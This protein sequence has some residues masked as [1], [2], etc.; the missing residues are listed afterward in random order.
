[1][2]QLMQ[3]VIEGLSVI[4]SETIGDS[5][6]TLALLVDILLPWMQSKSSIERKTTLLILRTTLRSYHDSLKYT[7]PGGK[8][9]PGKL[10]GR[11]LSWS[12][13]NDLTLRPLVIDCVALALNIG[14]RHRSTL[15]DNSLNQDLCESKRIIISEDATL[16]YQ[17]VR[18]LSKAAC[19]R[20]ASGEIVSLAEGLIEGLLYRGEGGIAAGIAL[21]ELFKLRGFDIPTANMYLIGKL[22]SFLIY[23]NLFL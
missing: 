20:V 2:S 7:Y 17:G 14:A 12:A 21:S 18:N 22:L 8:L 13:D 1:M 3:Q 15:P 5:A 9:E 10:L 16:L 23:T 6:D 19:A 11:F 4:S